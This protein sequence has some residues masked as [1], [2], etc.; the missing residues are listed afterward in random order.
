MFGYSMKFDEYIEFSFRKRQ[1]INEC[2]KKLKNK[3]QLDKYYYKYL[4]TCKITTNPW[5]LNLQDSL[6]FALERNNII[7]TCIFTDRNIKLFKNHK[8]SIIRY[9][10]NTYGIKPFS[11]SNYALVY[12]YPKLAGNILVEDSL[13]FSSIDGLIKN[14]KP[15]NSVKILIENNNKY[16]FIFAARYGFL[17][18]VKYFVENNIGI[19]YT[20]YAFNAAVDYRKFSMLK[21]LLTTTIKFDIDNAITH[22]ADTGD[23]K[24]MKL[25]LKSK[26]NKVTEISLFKI[27]AIHGHLDI[28]KYLIKKIHY[29]ETFSQNDYQY[30]CVNS[31][32][33]TIKYLIAHD[34]FVITGF[35]NL[36]LISYAFGADKPDIAEFLINYCGILNFNYDKIL[37]DLANDRG[38]YRIN[39]LI[40]LLN[41]DIKI[42]SVNSALKSAIKINKKEIAKHLAEYLMKKNYPLD[43]VINYATEKKRFDILM[44]LKN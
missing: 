35:K 37:C 34:K 38:Y 21:Y 1:A 31:N 17:E 41:K 33:E 25:F 26:L 22:S 14:P 8:T 4:N 28:V 12:G 7:K 32:L 5:H 10:L 6:F 24:L 11:L 39:A 29:D 20:Q 36:D 19:R 30:I 43:D 16:A 44:Y 15:S 18:K 40:Y 23:I 27:A 3:K 2:G 42:E 13:T 9:I